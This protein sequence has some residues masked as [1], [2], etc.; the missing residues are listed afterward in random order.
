M[1]DFKVSAADAE[2]AGFGDG[3]EQNDEMTLELVDLLRDVKADTPLLFQVYLQLVERVD[4]SCVARIYSAR[5]GLLN[6]GMI[7]AREDVMKVDYH[8]SPHG[9][10]LDI[11]QAMLTRVSELEYYRQCQN[12]FEAK[13]ELH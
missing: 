5:V 12:A 8:D 7:K 4:F 13:R 2:D 6:G 9:R 10:K 3:T 11:L 1:E